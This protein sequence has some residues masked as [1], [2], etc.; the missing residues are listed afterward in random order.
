MWLLGLFRKL[1]VLF[2]EGQSHC[3]LPLMHAEREGKKEKVITE[4]R[5]IILK[6]SLTRELS[7]SHFQNN[8]FNT[9]QGD[10]NNIPCSR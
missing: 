3:K 10:C 8:L 2:L 6:C 7:T 1:L 4:Y 5:V 9:A